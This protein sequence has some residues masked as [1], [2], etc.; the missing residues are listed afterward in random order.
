MKVVL[1]Y[2]RK[3]GDVNETR[4][5][6]FVRVL[7]WLTLYVGELREAEEGSD[8]LI[9]SRANGSH[10][11]EVEGTPRSLWLQASVLSITREE[12]GMLSPLHIQN[13]FERKTNAKTLEC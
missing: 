4:F 9:C 11:A 5:K 12:E 8:L 13:L 2:Q 7:T 3:E 1:Q 6:F 10:V